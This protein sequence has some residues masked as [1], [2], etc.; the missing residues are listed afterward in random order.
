MRGLETNA[1]QPKPHVGRLIDRV[2]G[3]ELDLRFLHVN[4]G[5]FWETMALSLEG[6]GSHP[7]TICRWFPCRQYHHKSATGPQTPRVSPHHRDGSQ[8][9]RDV[10]EF[11]RACLNLE[12]AVHWHALFL[13]IAARIA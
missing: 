7:W 2:N 11:E 4:L 3:A 5:L 1:A 12:V 13:H 8:K 6:T 9:G 10:A